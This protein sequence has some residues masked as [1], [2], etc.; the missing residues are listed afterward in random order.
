MFLDVLSITLLSLTGLF[1]IFY[2]K[3]DAQFRALD[4]Y[5]HFHIN[6]QIISESFLDSRF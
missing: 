5:I 2:C 6:V 1:D 3:L 4:F